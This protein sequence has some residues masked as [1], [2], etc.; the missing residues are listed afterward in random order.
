MSPDLRGHICLVNAKNI[1]FF[2]EID[3]APILCHQLCIN[4]TWL[5][6][7]AVAT[8]TGI[9]GLNE[10]YELRDRKS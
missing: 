7:V 5:F 4:L 9:F 10:V 8:S 1:I 3:I 2:A 6:T